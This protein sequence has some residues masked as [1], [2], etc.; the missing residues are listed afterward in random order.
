MWR[1]RGG[2]TEGPVF[3]VREAQA[4]KDVGYISQLPTSEAPGSICYQGLKENQLQEPALLPITDKFNR[5]VGFRA[6]WTQGLEWCYHGLG[7]P[8][9]PQLRGQ[10]GPAL[11]LPPANSIGKQSCSPGAHTD[12]WRRSRLGARGGLRTGECG[13]KG[14]CPEGGCGRGAGE[15]SAIP[16]ASFKAP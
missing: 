3:G 1:R 6:G 4:G 5:G 7:L 12:R 8:A 10:S 16:H 13:R 14:D 9:A 15:A 11:R 2:P